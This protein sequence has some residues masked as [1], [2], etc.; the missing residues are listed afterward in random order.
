MTNDPCGGRAQK[1]IL[2]ARTVRGYDNTVDVMLLG[3]VMNRT[4]SMSE[5]YLHSDVAH[6]TKLGLQ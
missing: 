4:S 6:S 5:Y 3:I 2:E 1:V